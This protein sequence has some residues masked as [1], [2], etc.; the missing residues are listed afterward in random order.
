MTKANDNK[1]DLERPASLD[2]SS[3]DD[4]DFNRDEWLRAQGEK[5]PFYVHDLTWTPA[6][7]KE[8]VRTFDFRVLTW[9]ALMCKFQNKI[10]I[11]H[12]NKNKAQTYTKQTKTHSFFFLSQ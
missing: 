9:I 1:L 3:L 12:I 5:N 8:I 6:E 7:E 10:H 2:N 11:N 4:S